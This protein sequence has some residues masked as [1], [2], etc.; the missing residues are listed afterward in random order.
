MKLLKFCTSP[1]NFFLLT[2]HQH[3]HFPSLSTIKSF[4]SGNWSSANIP[5][6]PHPSRSESQSWRS[7]LPR[8]T[9]LGYMHLWSVCT[10]VLLLQHSF[11]SWAYWIPVLN[12][13][14]KLQWISN[15]WGGEVNAEMVRGWILEQ[16]SK[17]RLLTSLATV[18]HISRCLSLRW[19]TLLS[20]PQVANHQLHIRPSP[21]IPPQPSQAASTIYLVLPL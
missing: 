11:V 2:G 7:I 16:V 15:N 19:Q 17:L 6:H 14:L 4:A 21:N 3:L 1:K 10:L 9:S 12:P 8:L 13:C 5:Y 20:P 18:A